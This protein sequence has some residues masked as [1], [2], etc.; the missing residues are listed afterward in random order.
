MSDQPAAPGRR[1]QVQEIAD[2]LRHGRTSAWIATVLSERHGSKIE[3]RRVTEFVRRHGLRHVEAWSR[4]QV[5]PWDVGRLHR[6]SPV[7]SLLVAHWQ[8]L[9]SAISHVSVAD[10]MRAH[11]LVEHCHE[12]DLVIAYDPATAQG[13]WLVH[14]GPDDWGLTRPG[15]Y[16]ANAQ[17]RTWV[18]TPAFVHPEVPAGEGWQ[19]AGDPGCRRLQRWAGGRECGLHQH[20]RQVGQPAVMPHD[21]VGRPS[22]FGLFGVIDRDDDGVLCHECGRWLRFLGRHIHREH[23]LDELQFRQRHGLA[24]NDPLCCRDMS[25][26][27]G[28]ASTE[29][30]GTPD[31][32]RFRS[33]GDAVA[34]QSLRAAAEASRRPAPGRSAAGAQRLSE[35]S[36]ARSDRW[37]DDRWTEQWQAARAWQARTGRWPRAGAAAE[38]ERQLGRWVLHQR[39]R[40]A[41]GRLPTRRRD[42]LLAGGFDF[43]PGG[44]DEALWDHRLA[45]LL[46]WHAAHDRWPVRSDGGEAQVLWRWM[47]RQ[48]A[49]ARAGQL[50]DRRRSLLAPV[51]E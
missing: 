34:E 50:T 37:D 39:E 27:I 13:F 3:H 41:A 30:I 46:A 22:G 36:K 6:A 14:R 49:A 25:Q 28:A 4:Q 33:A 15:R 48:R 42:A 21:E 31:W 23:D 47:C 44:R 43:E 8:M 2:W 35:M 12:R 29:R 32:K 17:P 38:E 26:A 16:D 7:L 40:E 24:A 5:I 9:T 18:P 10:M 11:R 51:L 20:R 19:C 45:A 1:L